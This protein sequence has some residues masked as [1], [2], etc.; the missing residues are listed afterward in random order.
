MSNFSYTNYSFNTICEKIKNFTFL[1][2]SSSVI[3][4]GMTLF[5]DIVVSTN[6]LDAQATTFMENYSTHGHINFFRVFKCKPS[7]VD[8]LLYELYIY[9]YVKCLY[10]G[11]YYDRISESSDLGLS[12]IGH[13]MFFE[14]LR[15]PNATNFKDDT[16]ISYRIQLGNEINRQALILRLISRFSFLRDFL[17]YNTDA[18]GTSSFFINK[19][20][21]L[22]NFLVEDFYSR[23]HFVNAEKDK[24]NKRSRGA[25]NYENGQLFIVKIGQA[26]SFAA[27]NNSPVINA[28]TDHSGNKLIFSTVRNGKSM[29]FNSSFS[30]SKANFIRLSDR[31]NDF[32]KV[33]KYFNN[34]ILT[35]DQ[36]H[37]VC[38]EVYAN[39]GIYC[40]FVGPKTSNVKIPTMSDFTNLI[41]DKNYDLDNIL[42]SVKRY[43]G[44]IR[45][46]ET[47][48]EEILGKSQ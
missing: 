13:S 24:D 41:K 40:R 37:L 39:T 12:F 25:Y 15:S 18:L 2:D 5:F 29:E 3:D 11:L 9:S 45:D 21:R 17:D 47:L 10:N 6:E 34:L 1:E 46:I 26:K 44:I 19:Y 35:N 38:S 22:L 27:F 48:V 28:F 14:L 42:E 7:E 30:F 33:E 36:R 8:D 43:E 23:D 16:L 31:N 32:D 20:E 4:K